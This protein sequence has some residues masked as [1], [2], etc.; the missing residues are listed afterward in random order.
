MTWDYLRSSYDAVAAKYQERFVD[1]LAG[2]PRD[3]ELLTS[4][5]ATVGDPVLDVG[6]GP[7][8]IGAFVGQRGHRVVGV[9]LSTRMAVLA[10]RRLD[11][12]VA[13]DMGALP[14]ATASCGG[15]LAFYSVIHLHRAE[16]GPVLREFAR[17]LR[18]GGH[19]L[20]SAHEGTGEV[21]RDVFL[22]Q[23][24]PFAATLF[25][26]DELVGATRSAGLDMTVAERRP[27]YTHEG[28]T[29]RLYVQATKAGSAR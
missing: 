29:V 6:C 13:A 20:F 21:H 25:E 14:M 9:D 10:L 15:V 1:E 5:A 7:G 17:V 28:G 26:L 23:S 2:K 4:F 27:P 19:V 16:L 11:T 8:Q 22:D 12:A 18:P 24:V 3:R